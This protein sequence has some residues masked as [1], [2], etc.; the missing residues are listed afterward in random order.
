MEEDTP[1]RT[2]GTSRTRLEKSK[3]AWSAGP[4]F[5]WGSA[6]LSLQHVWVFGI[7]VWDTYCGFRLARAESLN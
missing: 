1:D 7:D 2:G 3:K 6:L 4:C 5:V